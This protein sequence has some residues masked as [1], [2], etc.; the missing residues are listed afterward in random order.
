MATVSRGLPPQPHSDVPKR[1]AKELLAAFRARNPEALE[2]VRSNHPK[3]AAG[4]GTAAVAEPGL[5]LAD[6]QWVIAREY[7]FSSWSELK[8]RIDANQPALAL[9]DRSWINADALRLLE[10]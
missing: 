4:R 6:A 7:G 5:K 8:R 9:P 2:R 3:H 10:A 1:E